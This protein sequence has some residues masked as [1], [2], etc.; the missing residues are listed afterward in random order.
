M[1]NNNPI[2]TN[3]RNNDNDVSDVGEWRWN[4]D[5]DGTFSSGD[6]VLFHQYTAFDRAG[7]MKQGPRWG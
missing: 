2:I 3:D 1:D 5:G 6:G 4:E 7:N